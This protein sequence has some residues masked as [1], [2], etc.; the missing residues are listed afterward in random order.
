M[1]AGWQVGKC[2]QNIYLKMEQSKAITLLTM[3]QNTLGWQG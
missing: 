2:G 3:P 1:K